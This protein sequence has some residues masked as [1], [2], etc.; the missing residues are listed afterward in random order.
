MG[1]NSFRAGL[2]GGC[3]AWNRRATAMDQIA[4]IWG[5]GIPDVDKGTGIAL[6]CRSRPTSLVG[7]EK[8]FWMVLA[9]AAG[10]SCL[11][12]G[13]AAKR[14]QPFACAVPTG[15][16]RGGIRHSFR[17]RSQPGE[18]SDSQLL[19]ES[20]MMLLC[21]R[22]PYGCW[23]AKMGHWRHSCGA[24]EDLPAGSEG[25]WASN[26]HVLFFHGWRFAFLPHPVRTLV[27]RPQKKH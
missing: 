20:W 21:R 13:R 26:S 12:I 5:A 6:Q 22:A 2:K 11:L 10:R 14:G 17:T 23:L 1:M 19:T 25:N 16:G 7:R 27:G 4:R 18:R 8:A 3:E 9:A 24:A 15:A